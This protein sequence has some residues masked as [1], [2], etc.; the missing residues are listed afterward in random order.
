M[1]GTG[2]V[3][4]IYCPKVMVNKTGARPEKQGNKNTRKYTKTKNN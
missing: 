1:P 4:V 2:E 3:K